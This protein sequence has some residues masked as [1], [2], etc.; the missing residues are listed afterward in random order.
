CLFG[1]DRHQGR[2]AP[3]LL[4]RGRLSPGLSD[5]SSGP[6]VYRRE[7]SAEDREPEEDLSVALPRHARD[8]HGAELI[9][10]TSAM[11]NRRSSLLNSLGAAGAGAAFA[12]LGGRALADEKFE[13]T[14]TD[15]EWRKILSPDAYQVMRHEGTEPAGSSPLTDDTR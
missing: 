7:R 14:H 13:V 3:R 9:G 8:D 2:E 10:R 15:A 11:T 4:S 6:A 5:P 12:L 1:T